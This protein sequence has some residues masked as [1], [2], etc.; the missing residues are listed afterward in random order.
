[1]ALEGAVIDSQRWKKWLLP[2]EAG[3]D[4]SR[5]PAE[6]QGWLVATG[7]RYVWT[8]A[9]VQAARQRLYENLAGE[10]D[11]PH[12][13]VVAR[14]AARVERYIDAF[15]LRQSAKLLSS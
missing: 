12:G 4:F 2:E 7:A 15:H 6:R 5:L 13:Q 11:D 9:R 3:C 1:M 8:E 14:I 10:M